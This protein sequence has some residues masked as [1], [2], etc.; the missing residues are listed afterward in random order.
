MFER[1]SQH[2]RG[3]LTERME[4]EMD[5]CAMGPRQLQPA[6]VCSL[7]TER[8]RRSGELSDRRTQHG[9][10]TAVYVLCGKSL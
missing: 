9:F 2:A 5:A 8:Q 3:H 4:L 6:S 7:Q 10:N 1:K